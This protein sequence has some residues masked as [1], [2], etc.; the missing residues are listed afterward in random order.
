MAE[1]HEKD[2]D[3]LYS[4]KSRI[5]EEN[6]F[7]FENMSYNGHKMSEIVENIEK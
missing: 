6:Q 4:C 2:I 1:I 3:D 5:T 7:K